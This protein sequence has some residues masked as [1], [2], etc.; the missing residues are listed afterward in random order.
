MIDLFEQGDLLGLGE[1]Y[2]LRL[3]S[4]PAETAAVLGTALAVKA[5]RAFFSPFPIRKTRRSAD[6]FK[7]YQSRLWA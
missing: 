1:F 5:I 3:P 4:G 7:G 6:F 2:P